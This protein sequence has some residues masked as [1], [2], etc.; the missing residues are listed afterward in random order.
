MKRLY[1]L[2]TTG[3]TNDDSL[4][5]L[6]NNVEDI[7]TADVGL[8]DGERLGKGYPKNAKIYMNEENQG[9]KLSAM[10]G[11]S[12]NRIIVNRD[13][14]K[15]VEKHCGDAVEYLPFTLYDH[16]RRPYSKDYFILNP[17]G[18]YACLDLK[19]S[20]IEWSKD[21]PK[22]LIHIHTHVV[23]RSKLKGLPQLFRLD[24]EP[25]TYLLQYDLAKECHDR[26]FSNLT[27]W[28]LPF[29]DE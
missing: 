21:D 20:K 8:Y 24:L 19:K 28:K 16:R 14:K 6:D 23:D 27:W 11:N 26:D 7:G 10:L 12:Q 15:V 13:V 9:I 5:F 17:L 3:E 22:E 1:M 4:C 29:S 18:T 2:N 25:L